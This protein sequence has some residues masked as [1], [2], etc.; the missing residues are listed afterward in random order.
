MEGTQRMLPE[1]EA[2][3]S[4][5][6]Y[7]AAPV[8]RW[9][10][11]EVLRAGILAPS[12]KNRQP[13][14]FVVAMGESKAGLLRAMRAG[15]ARERVHPLLPESACHL[16]GAEHTLKVLAQAPVAILA[17][18]PLAAEIHRT[19]STEERVYEICNAQSLGAAMEN[20]SL[21][22]AHLGLGSLWICDTFFAQAELDAWLGTAGELYAAM[23]LGYSDE[24]PAA[25]PRRSFEET[26]EWRL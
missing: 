11:E 8:A 3:R 9:M 19:L 15:L 17:V 4:I 20:M 23:A 26:V 24:A 13:W 6:R 18:N 14:H 25:R 1:I 22:A 7:K 16:A 2:R 12:S 10:I 5:R 21:A